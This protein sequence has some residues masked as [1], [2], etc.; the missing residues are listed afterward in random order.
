MRTTRLTSRT[1][2]NGE[3]LQQS[4]PVGTHVLEKFVY[5]ALKRLGKAAAACTAVSGA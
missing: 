2:Q 1:V 3:M 4:A 5:A